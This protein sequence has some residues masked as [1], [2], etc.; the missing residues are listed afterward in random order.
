M[1]YRAIY[2]KRVRGKKRFKSAA[3]ADQY[4]RRKGGSDIVVVPFLKSRKRP[5]R[6][7]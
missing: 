2:S 1:T 6:R 4:A 3:A 7:R 5:R